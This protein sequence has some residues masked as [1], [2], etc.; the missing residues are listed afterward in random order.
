MKRIYFLAKLDHNYYTHGYTWEHKLTEHLEKLSI[1]FGMRV[2]AQDYVETHDVKKLK[3][4][5]N[6]ELKAYR[7]PETSLLH[8][9]T[10]M[11]ILEIMLQY[12]GETIDPTYPP[13]PPNIDLNS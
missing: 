3:N 4:Q 5:I 11:P 1:S 8:I 6:K 7:V 9:S 10:P 12:D 2:I 13:K